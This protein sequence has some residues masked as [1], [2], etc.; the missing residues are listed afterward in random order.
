[1]LPGIGFGYAVGAAVFWGLFLFVNKRYFAT[2]P[3]STFMSLTFGAAAL[4]YLPVAVLDGGLPPTGAADV[5]AMSA[6]VALLAAGLLVLFRAIGAGEV[7]YVAPLGK[8]TPALVLPIE[9]A[10]VG[11]VVGPVQVAGVV[12]VT[13]AVYLVNYRGEAG[14]LG[15]FR[16]ALTRRPARLALLSALLL[17]VM[18]VLQR[19]VLQE[20][21]VPAA[22]W[23]VLKLGGAALLLAPV[24]H[25][26]WPAKRR[27]EAGRIV[28]A[29]AV[30]VLGEHCIAQTFSVLSA[31]VA[32]PVVSTQA[33]VATLLGGVVL[34]E[35]SLGIRLTAAGLAAGGVAMVALG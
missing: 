18:T 17:A 7:S 4:L 35:E 20:L 30:L 6:A 8:V 28:A 9:V 34:G 10:V 5:G 2:Y 12:V 11:Q 25:R 22:A 31:S 3:S 16:A 27:P 1:V 21:S 13:A 14:L 29:A 33:I 32:T 15:P 19:V 26:A 23:V 24:A